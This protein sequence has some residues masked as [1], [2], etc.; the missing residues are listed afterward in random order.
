MLDKSVQSLEPFGLLLT[1][2]TPG[3]VGS[4][5]PGLGLAERAI[6]V[7][8]DA[9]PGQVMGQHWPLDGPTGGP[10]SLPI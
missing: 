1:P 8:T 6:K 3:E 2:R 7:G 4:G 10:Y 5:H 9:S